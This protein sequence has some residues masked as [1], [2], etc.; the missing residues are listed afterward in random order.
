MR[1]YQVIIV[2]F[3]KPIEKGTELIPW[4]NHITLV[5]FFWTKNLENLTS[6]VKEVCKNFRPIEYYVDGIEYLGRRKNVKTSK[7][8]SDGIIEL[9]KKFH[10]LAAKH[11]RKFHSGF[12]KNGFKPHITH[13]V[14]PYPAEGQKEKIKDIYLVLHLYPNKKDKKV[15]D[16]IK[17]G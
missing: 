14:A 12:L 9:Q 15:L 10:V 13:N 4:P 3:L 16:I 7:V 17:L 5:P 8:I 1:R 2:S 11:D 6:Q